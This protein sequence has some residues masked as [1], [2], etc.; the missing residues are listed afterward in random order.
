MA[1]KKFN[2]LKVG[3]NIYFC[4]RYNRFNNNTILYGDAMKVK[5]FTIH[6]VEKFT[7]AIVFFD[8]NLDI[9]LTIPK[10]NVMKYY[11]SYYTYSTSKEFIEHDIKKYLKWYVD[12]LKWKIKEAKNAEKYL[13]QLLKHNLI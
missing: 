4:N 1:S 9:Q 5:I 8:Y 12:S 6:K 7:N 10:K 13:N 2:E 11:A 3:D